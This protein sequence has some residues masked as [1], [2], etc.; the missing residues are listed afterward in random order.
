MEEARRRL[1]TYNSGREW[2]LPG[3]RTHDSRI[4][5]AQETSP[6]RL[7]ALT[8]CRP[9]IVCASSISVSLAN[10]STRPSARPPPR[11]LDFTL[12]TC[13][14]QAREAQ[15]ITV[16]IGFAAC[17]W[18]NVPPDSS[19]LASGGHRAHRCLSECGGG[20]TGGGRTRCPRTPAGRSGR[21]GAP[22][23]RLRENEQAEVARR[24]RTSVYM[25]PLRLEPG[26]RQKGGQPLLAGPGAQ[27]FDHH[28]FGSSSLYVGPT[29]RAT[30]NPPADC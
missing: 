24:T 9:A 19:A 8:L 2:R 20:Q 29:P 10:L 4:S 1:S 7:G 14:L 3:A 25:L 11:Y 13:C 12:F 6:G 26:G 30:P 5:V 17:L 16:S 27:L 15:I 28:S 18:H 22:R 23:G 21:A